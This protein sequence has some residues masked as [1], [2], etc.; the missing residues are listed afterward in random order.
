MQQHTDG[1]EIT[2]FVLVA[3][4]TGHPGADVSFEL[5]HAGGT[6]KDD[7]GAFLRRQVPPLFC[8]ARADKGRLSL[9]VRPI[10]EDQIESHLAH[11]EQ[12]FSFL[13]SQMK[14]RDQP[15]GSDGSIL[16]AL[17]GA[18]GTLI[19]SLAG[20]HDWLRDYFVP[21][22]TLSVAREIPGD[23]AENVAAVLRVFPGGGVTMLRSE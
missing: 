13:R 18:P 11:A 14:L 17:V 10:A 2:L 5:P 22:R 4:I 7:A 6:S 12:Q 3:S 20:L 8:S 23:I 15:S 21:N 1:A 9:V 19:V 16:I